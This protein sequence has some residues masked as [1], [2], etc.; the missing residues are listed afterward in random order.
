MDGRIDGL[1][2]DG[3]LHAF[4][5]WSSILQPPK[6]SIVIVSFEPLN[7][8]LFDKCLLNQRLISFLL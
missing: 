1:T 4:R 8:W 2:I 7:N 3:I 6:V 5:K